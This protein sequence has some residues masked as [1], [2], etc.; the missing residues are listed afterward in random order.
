MFELSVG[1]YRDKTLPFFSLHF[2]EDGALYP[3]IHP[4]YQNTLVGVV[5]SYIDYYMKGFL[6]GGV[7]QY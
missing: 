2:N 5:I 3:V 4:S 7:F 6:N 1:I